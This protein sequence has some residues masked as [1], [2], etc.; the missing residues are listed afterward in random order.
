MRNNYPSRNMICFWS[1]ILDPQPFFRAG[2]SLS[3]GSSSFF[4][5]PRSLVLTVMVALIS[6]WASFMRS[7]KTLKN[8]SDLLSP[9]RR[10]KN[11]LWGKTRKKQQQCI[12]YMCSLWCGC[13]LADDLHS[14]FKIGWL[15]FPLWFWSAACYTRDSLP[16]NFRKQNF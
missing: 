16:S 10:W 11:D 4:L 13:I 12:Y 2:A 3:A 15:N 5:L 1:V 14:E 7:L 8:F 9:V 6:C